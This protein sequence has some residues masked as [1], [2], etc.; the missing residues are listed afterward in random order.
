MIP[1]RGLIAVGVRPLV[2]PVGAWRPA[3]AATAWRRVDRRV[4]PQRAWESTEAPVDETAST[5]AEEKE[6]GHF[7]V[8]SNESILFFTSMSKCCTPSIRTDLT[9]SRRYLS[10]QA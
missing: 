5:V 4:L 9:R 3:L 8:K 6:T 1:S 2:R 7:D 10:T